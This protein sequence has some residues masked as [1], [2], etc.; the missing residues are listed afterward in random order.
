MDPQMVM[1]NRERAVKV[2]SG[3]VMLPVVLGVLLGSIAS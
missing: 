3:W 2:S 1:S